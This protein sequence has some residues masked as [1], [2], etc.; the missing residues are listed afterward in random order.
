MS[1][2]A[3]GAVERRTE[4]RIERAVVTTVVLVFWAK[5]AAILAAG[6]V[7]DRRGGAR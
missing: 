6:W 4:Q 7:S 3:R 2:P 5:R 1:A